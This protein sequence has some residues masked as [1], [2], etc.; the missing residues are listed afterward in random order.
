MITFVA[1]II[2][3]NIPHLMND[4]NLS[5]KPY[6]QRFGLIF[7]G[8][9]ILI[10]LLV[11]AFNYTQNFGISILNLVT[12]IFIVFYAIHLYKIDNGAQLSFSTALKIGLAVGAIG[13]V[14][15]A[16]YNYIH[17]SYIQPEFIEAMKEE[18]ITAI[19][20]EIE[21]QSMKPKEAE[22]AKSV[23][24]IFTSPFAIST[25]AIISIMLKTFFISLFVG[26]IKKN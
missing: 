12:N 16:I 20:A 19:E 21:R 3:D 10:L 23:A 26:L 22:V 13:G 1:S 8:A 2:C 6:A 15:Y 14:L 18:S 25:M 7:G 11:F 9:Q 17:Y 24:L 4:Q 5:I